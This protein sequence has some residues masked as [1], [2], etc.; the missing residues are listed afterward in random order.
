MSFLQGI[1]TEVYIFDSFP[2]YSDVLNSVSKIMGNTISDSAG[3]TGSMYKTS[4]HL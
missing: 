1:L 4:R 3:A 2:I